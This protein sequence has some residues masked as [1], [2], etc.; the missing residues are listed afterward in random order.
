MDMCTIKFDKKTIQQDIQKRKNSVEEWKK[1]IAEVHEKFIGDAKAYIENI[2]RL[3]IRF[4]T[5]V[6]NKCNKLEEKKYPWWKTRPKLSKNPMFDL[7]GYIDSVNSYIR[8]YASHAVIFVETHALSR[9]VRTHFV[10]DDNPACFESYLRTLDVPTVMTF[11]TFDLCTTLFNDSEVDLIDGLNATARFVNAQ[12]GPDV[13]IDT[14]MCTRIYGPKS[15]YVKPDKYT[16][17]VNNV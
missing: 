10:F 4:K 6:R 7:I 15:I 1:E 9:Y 8:R 12:V 13:L 11:R 3:V 2:E 16:I 5:A 14:N 17:R